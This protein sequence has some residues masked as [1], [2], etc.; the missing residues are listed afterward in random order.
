[1]VFFFSLHFVTFSGPR[2]VSANVCVFTFVRRRNRR[3][4]RHRSVISHVISSNR[5]RHHLVADGNLYAA[6]P[7]PGLPHR[8]RFVVRARRCTRRLVSGRRLSPRSPGAGKV[9]VTDDDDAQ[10]RDDQR[11]TIVA[12]KSHHYRTAVTK[13]QTAP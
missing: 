3:V 2:T 4:L 13:R 6:K 5:A 12:Q 7:R 1:M 9:I 8:K 10:A 11:Q